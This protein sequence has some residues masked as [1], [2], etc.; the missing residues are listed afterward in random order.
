MVSVAR[1]WRYVGM[2]LAG[3]VGRLLV[4]MGVVGGTLALV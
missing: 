1:C 2:P 3:S 4:T